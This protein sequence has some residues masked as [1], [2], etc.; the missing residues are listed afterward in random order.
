ML[1]S[2]CHAF[3]A[4]QTAISKSLGEHGSCTCVYRVLSVLRIR[5]CLVQQVACCG[6]VAGDTSQSTRCCLLPCTCSILSCPPVYEPFLIG[7]R[8]VNVMHHLLF[9]HVM[10][11]A[12][13]SVKA[14]CNKLGVTVTTRHCET[15]VNEATTAT[16]E[17][18][19][20]IP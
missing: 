16:L 8:G 10:Q 2:V 15:V 7:N 11:E 1:E 4:R 13:V 5:S 6:N 20:P 3:A 9:Q 17:Y 14:L 18:T 12:G 19:Q